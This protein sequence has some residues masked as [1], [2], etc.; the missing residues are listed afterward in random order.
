MNRKLLAVATTVFTVMMLFS[1]LAVASA[2]PPVRKTVEFTVRTAAV[3]DTTAERIV[4]SDD[5][6]THKFGIIRTVPLESTV[7]N[8]PVKNVALKINGVP[9]Y[10]TVYAEVNVKIDPNT[11]VT[12]THYLKWLLTFPVQPGVD[13][14][15]A[16]EGVHTYFIDTTPSI[17]VVGHAVLQGSGGFEGQTL[18][19]K[20]VFPPA[21]LVWKGDLLIK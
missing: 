4:I 6:I 9:I 15:G 17:S 1:F 10:G 12:S 2:G 21:P 19:L 14:E 11:G 7:N 20:V 13:V 18:M 8:A 3:S 16:F 5:G